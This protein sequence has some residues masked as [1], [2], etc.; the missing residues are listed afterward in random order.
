M[1]SNF[2]HLCISLQLKLYIAQVSR[3]LEVIGYS[4]SLIVLIFALATFCYFRKLRKPRVTRIHMNLFASMI[5]QCL[6]R[7]VIYADQWIVRQQSN[8]QPVSQALHQNTIQDNLTN[9][10]GTKDEVW[11][12]DNTPLLCE[13]FYT[14]IEYGKTTMFLWMFIEGIILYHMTTVA[15]SRG[16]EHQNLFYV[17]GWVLPIP[18]TIAWV[19]TKFYEKEAN[20]THCGIGYSLLSSYWILE[21]PR[22]A[23]IMVKYQYFK[24]FFI[25]YFFSAEY[26]DTFK[27]DTGTIFTS[28]WK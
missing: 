8:T 14:L 15:Y 11:G 7:L 17:V 20:S 19:T 18:L 3:I 25:K 21:G 10:S 26:F 9:V 27:C 24:V 16:P 23:C 5:L 1:V 6:V 2:S 28:I 4:I 12:I 22:I 13:V